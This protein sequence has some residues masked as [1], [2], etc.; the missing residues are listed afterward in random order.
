MIGDTDGRV[1]ASQTGVWDGDQDRSDWLTGSWEL[2]AK[3][4]SRESAGG[5][6]CSEA[7][8]RKHEQTR[9]PKID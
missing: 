1:A 5:G 8:Q 4:S 3:I 6:G 2:A 7:S 9:T